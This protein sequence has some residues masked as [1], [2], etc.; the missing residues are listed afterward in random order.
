MVWKTPL[1]WSG[2]CSIQ[3]TTLFKVKC[4]GMADN[5]QITDIFKRAYMLC[6]DDD[7]ILV[8]SLPNIPKIWNGST[9]S[10]SGDRIIDKPSKS[11]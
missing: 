7:V 8:Y 10:R 5:V 11:T 3:P 2:A 1:H 6:P 9:D 4:F